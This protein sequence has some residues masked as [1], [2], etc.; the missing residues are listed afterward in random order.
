M[1]VRDK[2][3]NEGIHLSSVCRINILR[4]QVKLEGYLESAPT[5]PELCSGFIPFSFSHST[6][7][8]ERKQ[9]EYFD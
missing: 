8:C 4:R 3:G 2:T 9:S 7:T 6:A 5:N 1:Q